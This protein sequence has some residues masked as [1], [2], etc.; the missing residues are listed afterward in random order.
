MT[1]M[2][3]APTDEQTYYQYLMQYRAGHT[4]EPMLAQM[5]ASSLCAKGDMPLYLGLPLD[6]F[7]QVMA[8]YF[9]NLPH[10]PLPAT[11]RTLDA[12]RF[13]ELEDLRQLLR[14]HVSQPE[15][16][17]SWMTAIL[18]AGCM[19]NNHLWQD[20]G[21]W[22]RQDLSALIYYNF[23]TLAKLNN[24]DMK[25]KKFLYKQMCIGE[26]IY[27]CRSPSCEICVDYAACFGPEN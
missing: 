8:Y 7:R 3:K 22:S 11:I 25:W 27:V 21:L 12:D 26:G 6:S 18:C 9:P 17:A 14:Q 15:P 5:L 2:P 20:L 10:L 13:P 1:S 4:N 24:K 16:I 23:S 19:G